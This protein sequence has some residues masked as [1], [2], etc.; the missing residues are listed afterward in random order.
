MTGGA[1]TALVSWRKECG[2]GGDVESEEEFGLRASHETNMCGEGVCCLL[3]AHLADHVRR[4][5]PAQKYERGDVGHA[6][7]EDDGRGELAA[8]L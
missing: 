1:S 5:V 3:L 6:Q 4:S 2:R 7:Q 8:E